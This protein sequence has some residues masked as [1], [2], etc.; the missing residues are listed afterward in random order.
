MLNFKKIGK[1]A[2]NL[3]ESIPKIIQDF[4]YDLDTKIHKILYKQINRMHFVN[5]EEFNLQSQILLNIQKTL[6]Q[7]EKKL[8]QLEKKLEKLE[9]KNTETP[10]THKNYNQP[11]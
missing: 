4:T 9:E 2:Q 3:H 10:N 1:F 7:L 6:K 8:K 5:Q 11:K